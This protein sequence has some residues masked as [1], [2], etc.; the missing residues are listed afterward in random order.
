MK[1]RATAI[2]RP[3]RKDRQFATGRNNQPHSAPKIYRQ[4]ISEAD[5]LKITLEYSKFDVQDGTSFSSSKA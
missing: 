4:N 2:V 3:G 1:S 5:I